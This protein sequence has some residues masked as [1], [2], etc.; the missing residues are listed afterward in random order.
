MLL[1][2]SEGRMRAKYRQKVNTYKRTDKKWAEGRK[3]EQSVMKKALILFN[4]ERISIELAN[5]LFWRWTRRSCIFLATNHAAR[6]FNQQNKMYFLM[7][8]YAVIKSDYRQKCAGCSNRPVERVRARLRCV[9]KLHYSWNISFIKP[10][11]YSA[12]RARGYT[13]VYP[14]L[15]TNYAP[16]LQPAAVNESL[17]RYDLHF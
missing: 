2:I 12:N 16:P 3:E 7:Q 1:F 10:R 4:P 14:W 17:F 5:N 8:Q 15:P 9:Y 11:L 13:Y 6:I